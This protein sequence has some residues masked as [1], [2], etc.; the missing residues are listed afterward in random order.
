M[1][2]VA[3]VVIIFAVIIAM[4]LFRASRRVTGTGAGERILE[5]RLFGYGLEEAR[6]YL[7]ALG[8]GKRKHY[9]K[10]VIPLDRVF[11]FCYGALGGWYGL[12]LSSALSRYGYWRLSWIALAGGL[13]FVT[14]AAADVVEGRALARM[15]RSFPLLES[16]DAAR[17]ARA[18][19]AKWAAVIIGAAMLMLFSGVV[20][21]SW[22][23]A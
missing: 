5:S 4:F 23:K 12:A 16:A 20:A 2:R 17:A 9:L 1:A 22:L 19:I 13:C 3:I 15:L 7:A 21:I 14:A 18:T 8:P 6:A 10:R 11:A